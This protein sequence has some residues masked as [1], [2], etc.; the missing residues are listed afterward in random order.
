MATLYHYCSTQTFHSIVNGKSLWLS[1]LAQSNDHM[2]GKLLSH[3]VERLA[4]ADGLD[5]AATLRI[6]E[7]FTRMENLFDGLGFCLSEEGDLLS[8]WRGYADD[9]TGFSIGLDEAY[10]NW[11]VESNREEKRHGLNLN[12]VVYDD[13]KQDLLVS[14]TY[15]EI[16]RAIESGALREPGRRGLLD[17]RSEEEIAR[18]DEEIRL[19][20][21]EIFGKPLSL[22][23]HIYLLKSSAFREEREWRL[24]SYYVGAV[25]D[26]CSFRAVRGQVVPYR[27]FDL[28]EIERKPIVEVVLGPKQQTPVHVVESF[29]QQAGFGGVPVTKSKA[30]YR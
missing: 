23:R 9:A 6:Q 21:M 18:E 11:L 22:V 28:R 29:L 20:S 24:V 3:A 13:D 15:I 27:A 7:L 12:S 2:E 25:G 14:P 16:K 4:H 17:T 5:S 1:S 10:L 8:Q 19:A 30:T 26:T